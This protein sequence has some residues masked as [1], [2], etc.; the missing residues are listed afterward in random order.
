MTTSGT[1]NDTPMTFNERTRNSIV[2]LYNYQKH[3]GGS[4]RGR[5][6]G[7]AYEL[8][9]C[10]N[11]MVVDVDIDKSLEEDKKQTIRTTLLKKLPDDACVVQT[12][13][14]GLHI[15]CNVDGFPVTSNR[16][17]KC[18][19]C[20]DFDIDLLS[21]VD[22]DKRSLVVAPGSSVRATTIADG[23][24]PIHRYAVVRES[25]D[26]I[27]KYNCNDILTML[28]ISIRTN[29]RDDLG[30]DINIPLE[31]VMTSI[32]DELTSAIVNG[33][34]GLEIHNDAQPIDREITLFTLFQ[35]IN[36]LHPEHIDSAYDFIR[37]NCNLTVNARANFDA[38]R[39][40]YSRR[41]THPGVLI[42]MIRI[43]NPTYYE[44]KIKPILSNTQPIT[45][46][47]IDIRDPFSISS[48]NSKKYREEDELKLVE[49]MS[50]VFRANIKEQIY[51]MKSYDAIKEIYYIKYMN[52][53][54]TSQIMKMFTLWKCEM[55]MVTMWDIFVKHRA[56]FD[57]EGPRFYSDDWVEDGGGRVM[58]I[59]QGYDFEEVDGDVD[60]Y[61][62][63]IEPF[64]DHVDQVI[65]NHDTDVS[66]YVHNWIASLIQYPGEKLESAIVLKGIE[67][68][69]KNIFTST[70]CKL[71][72]R[73]A[74]DNINDINELV[75]NF[76]SVVENK[77]LLVLNELKNTGDERFANLE[78]LKSIIT[79]KTIR[80][81]EKNQ[82]RRTAENVANIIFVSN[83]P[84]PVNL[85][86]NDRRFCVIECSSEK[87]G[88]REY[89]S[90]LAE[91][92]K[93]GTFLQILFSYYMSL[94]VSEFEPRDIPM[95]E[96]RRTMIEI[97]RPP[98]EEWI[99][100][101][102]DELVAGKPVKECNDCAKFE[103]G[104]KSTSFRTSISTYCNVKQL[105]SHNKARCYVLKKEYIEKLKPD[106]GDEAK[107]EQIDI[108]HPL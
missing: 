17:V 100:T 53:E 63:M 2:D 88:D 9:K 91:L 60:P 82:P 55:K 27:I 65:C 51:M 89:F 68:C 20:E 64:I 71:I 6:T 61:M 21:G 7:W 18:Y 33:F 54:T 30:V 19:K 80:I 5:Q 14:G 15:Y 43:H 70:I 79:D 23:E 10:E 107:I 11:L 56:C 22:P 75:G 74:E 78:Q 29:E 1:P 42:K 47:K 13:S 76:N 28:D 48:M 4:G 86:V 103:L 69:G 12:P 3:D 40:R 106:D 104:M 72:G 31:G 37:Q 108:S 46:H 105:A 34:A 8:N 26:D 45:I 84:R 97:C 99:M 49:D 73:Y 62:F 39:K 92:T 52:K 102:Y 66:E 38:T 90:N 83:N 98:I 57:V 96:A 67:G 59:F 87:V 25:S 32:S 101:H 95:T 24:R 35:G 16:M 81:N 94:D 44:E 85:T 41:I 77:M 50:R 36:S 93:N 58:S